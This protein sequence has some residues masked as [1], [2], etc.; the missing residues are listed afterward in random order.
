MAISS[1]DVLHVA[2]LAR[3]KVDE[4]E[5]ELFRTQLEA[6]LEHAASISAIDTNGIEPTSHPLAMSNVFRD[7]VVTPSLTQDQA[8]LNAPDSAQGRFSV[9]QILAEDSE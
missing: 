1:D 5:V 2:K 8:L 4:D 3:L 6:I 9:P 7:D